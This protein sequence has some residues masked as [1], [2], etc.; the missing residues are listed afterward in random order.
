MKT[1]KKSNIM[2]ML[3]LCLIALAGIISNTACL[4]L[5]GEVDPPISLLNK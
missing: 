3:G 2:N 5:W 4:G 1:V